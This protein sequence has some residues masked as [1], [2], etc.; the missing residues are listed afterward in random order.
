LLKLYIVSDFDVFINMLNKLGIDYHTD[1]YY[2]THRVQVR[3]SKFINWMSL[4][5]KKSN[6]E[7][8]IIYVFDKDKNYL[9]NAVCIN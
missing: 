9:S 8:V 5:V 2:T 3:S 6:E 4:L 7:C 1:I